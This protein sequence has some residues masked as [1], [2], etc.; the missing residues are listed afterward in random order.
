[1]A[2]V[3]TGDSLREQNHGAE[4]DGHREVV[5]FNDHVPQTGGSHMLDIHDIVGDALE[6]GETT[7][8]HVSNAKASTLGNPIVREFDL[9]VEMPWATYCRRFH[10]PGILLKPNSG[11]LF[12]IRPS[13][14]CELGDVMKDFSLEF[15]FYWFVGRLFHSV[16]LY[17]LEGSVNYDDELRTAQAIDSKGPKKLQAFERLVYQTVADQRVTHDELWKVQD[18]RVQLPSTVPAVGSFVCIA[19]SSLGLVILAL[20]VVRGFS[21]RQVQA[22]Y[23]PFVSSTS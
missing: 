11:P 8:V 6:A 12:L 5:R 2:I 14:F 16:D 15:L 18:K 20:G 3:G 13:V 1:M 9:D 19:L 23:S 22:A 21:I 10:E 17:G 4:I 7:T